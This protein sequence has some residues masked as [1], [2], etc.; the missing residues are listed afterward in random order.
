LSG[1]AIPPL[2][3]SLDV[4]IR[5]LPSGGKR[6][7]GSRLPIIPDAS[8]FWMGVGLAQSLIELLC[9]DETLELE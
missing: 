3:L 8:N 6:L 4:S 9:L 1:V 7:T 5:V 2:V